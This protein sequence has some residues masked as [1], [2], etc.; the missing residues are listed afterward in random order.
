MK[1]SEQNDPGI[2]GRDADVQRIAATT[3]QE[4]LPAGMKPFDVSDFDR[5]CSHLKSKGIPVDDLSA[6]DDLRTLANE[7]MTRG[8]AANV[9]TDSWLDLQ[10]R[11]LEDLNNFIGKLTDKAAKLSENDPERPGITKQIGGILDF[12]KG[13]CGITQDRVKA[14]FFPDIVQEEAKH[15][16]PNFVLYT[17]WGLANRRFAFFMLSAWVNYWPQGAQRDLFRGWLSELK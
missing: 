7:A 17:Q 16:A 11:T 3:D 4:A 6:L 12:Q 2:H 10:Q 8:E 5:F 1:K 14:V 9:I 13:L 15:K